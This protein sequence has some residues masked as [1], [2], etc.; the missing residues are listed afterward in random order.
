M[1]HIGIDI[2]T[3]SICGVVY[4]EATGQV[5]SVTKANDAAVGGGQAIADDIPAWAFRQN[6]NRIFQVVRQLLDE[7]IETDVASIGF[8]GQMHGMLYLDAAGNPVSPLYTWQDGSAA[9]PFRDGKSYA[10]LYDKMSASATSRTDGMAVRT[11]FEGTRRDSALRGQI[12][13]IDLRNL[14]PDRLTTAFMMGICQELKDY[15]DFLP[16][17]VK[18]GRTAITGSGNALRKNPLLQKILS[19]TFGLPVVLTS[20]EEEAALGAAIAYKA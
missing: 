11:T 1:K 9:Q 14:S 17:S 15:Y 16:E 20:H 8:S 13:E 19:E 4:D 5:R 18:K 6:P 10:D 3:S 2:G 7:M 12:S